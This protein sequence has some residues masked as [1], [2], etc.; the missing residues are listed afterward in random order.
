LIATQIAVPFRSIKYVLSFE[1]FPS[2]GESDGDE[3]D[4]TLAFVDRITR[5]WLPVVCI[6]DGSRCG[7]VTYMVLVARTI[8]DVARRRIPTTNRTVSSRWVDDGAS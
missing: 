2:S 5:S 6:G 4:Q 7:E 3:Y 1:Q 8:G